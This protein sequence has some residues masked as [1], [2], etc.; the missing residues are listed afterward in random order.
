ML[1]LEEAQ[2]GLLSLY[3]VSLGHIT[4]GKH[5]LFGLHKVC[6]GRYNGRADDFH[7]LVMQPVGE[8]QGLF[9]LVLIGKN[10]ARFVRSFKMHALNVARLLKDDG[11]WPCAKTWSL[12]IVQS[13]L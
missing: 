3:L 9:P 11:P 12:M 1:R 6:R 7:E 13:S 2:R 5:M 8:S 4:A 10:T